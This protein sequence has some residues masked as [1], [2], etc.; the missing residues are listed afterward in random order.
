MGEKGL[1]SRDGGISWFVLNC[2]GWLGIP[3]QVPRGTQGA[4]RV[5]SGKSSLHS[6]CKGEPGSALDSREDDEASFSMER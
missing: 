6:S 4:S 1:I 5:A 2:G 3:L